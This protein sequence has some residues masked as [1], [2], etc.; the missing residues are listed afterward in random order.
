MHAEIYTIK[1]SKAKGVQSETTNNL[2]L[3]QVHRH[4]T[5]QHRVFEK[6][7]TCDKHRNLF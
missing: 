7:K 5:I 3:P 2:H 4:F 6:I 1:L